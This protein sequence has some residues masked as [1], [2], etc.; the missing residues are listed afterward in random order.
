MKHLLKGK[1]Q[2][3]QTPEHNDIAI[4]DKRDEAYKQ[5]DMFADNHPNGIELVSIGLLT[6]CVFL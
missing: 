5:S 1:Y 6:F 2:I 4:I 3:Q